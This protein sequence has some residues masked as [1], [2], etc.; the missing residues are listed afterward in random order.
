MKELDFF[1]FFGSGY[2]YLSVMRIED[3]AA[4]A[5]VS[6][7]WRPFSVRTLMIEEGNIIRNQP[8]KMH[9]MWRDVERRAANCSTCASEDSLERRLTTSPSRRTPCGP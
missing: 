7:R 2:A 6:V 4:A 9:Y 8:A 1:Y 5:G 3:L